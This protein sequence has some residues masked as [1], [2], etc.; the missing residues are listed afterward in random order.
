MPLFLNHKQFL[1]HFNLLTLTQQTALLAAGFSIADPVS[2]IGANEMAT[3]LFSGLTLVTVSGDQND[4]SPPSLGNTAGWRI[5]VSLNSEITGIVAPLQ[6]ITYTLYNVGP[7]DL[8]LMDQDS[9]SAAANRFA[10]K[11][12]S[13]YKIES[14]GAAQIYYDDIISRWAIISTS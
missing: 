14:M 2:G 9:G 8:T 6:P 7:Q 1:D 10:L 3:N 13:N 4:W 11:N 5:T 12:T